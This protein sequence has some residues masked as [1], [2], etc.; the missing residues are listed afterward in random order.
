MISIRWRSD[1]LLSDGLPHRS[2]KDL[3]KSVDRLLQMAWIGSHLFVILANSSGT[4]N[5]KNIFLL[6]FPW[7]CIFLS[8]SP[9]FYAMEFDAGIGENKTMLFFLISCS[10]VCLTGCPSVNTAQLEVWSFWNEEHWSV[11]WHQVRN[12]AI[13]VCLQKCGCHSV[14]LFR[15]ELGYIW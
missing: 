8:H 14:E 10:Q 2:W 9:F 6:L 4:R 12:R 1:W 11:P 5:G 7:M 13:W 15:K 3:L